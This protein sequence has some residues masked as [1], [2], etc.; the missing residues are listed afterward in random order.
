MPRAAAKPQK[1]E[2]H[3]RYKTAAE[4]IISRATT[5]QEKA[6]LETMK[7]QEFLD[8][9]ARTLNRDPGSVS[10]DDTPETVEE[11]DSIGHLL[12]VSMLES[13]LGVTPDTEEMTSFN[14]MSQ[15]V[16]VLKGKGALED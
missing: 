1:N 15:L 12:L 7:V 10:L 16:D 8:T 5:E 9:V 13:E 3:L 4:E 2:S 14:S 6:S 11:W